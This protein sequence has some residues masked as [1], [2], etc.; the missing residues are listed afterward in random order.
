MIEKIRNEILDNMY[1]FI[2]SLDKAEC[3]DEM[4]KLDKLLD[5]LIA[6]VK[7]NCND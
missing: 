3:E 7:R 2:D 4:K 5:R 6:E 1:P